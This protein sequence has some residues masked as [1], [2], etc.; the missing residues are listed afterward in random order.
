MSK[1]TGRSSLLSLALL[2]A[3]CAASTALPTARP[4]SRPASEADVRRL[5]SAL[6]DDSMAGRTTGSPGAAR[7][8]RY[9]AEGL[10][11]A[12]VTPAGDS[13]YFQRVPTRYGPAVNVV[14]VIRGAEGP[15]SDSAVIVA[16]HYDHLG[17]GRPVAGD[18]IYNGADDDAS[19]VVAVLEIARALAHERVG[20]TVVV[21]L[22]TGEEQ[23]LLGTGRYLEAP[24]VPLTRTV[25]QLEIEMIGRPDSLAGG[26]GHAWLTGYERSTLGDMLKASGSPIVPDPRPGEN[27]FERSDNIA[28][29]RRGIPAHTLSSFNLHTDYH[30][31]SD[32]V[33][34]VDFAHMTAVVHAAIAAARALVDGPAP[35]WKPGG[36]PGAGAGGP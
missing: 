12:G 18:S 23:G 13:A 24:A 7:A 25:A 15:A 29:A 14:G 22:T 4:T 28:F 2:L 16:A 36:R 8:A 33:S 6:A 34:H 30:R 26:A 3:A 35:E 17:A 27:F 20:R 19:G 11:A 9:I 10:A 5:L 31:P 1:G 21:L 32:D